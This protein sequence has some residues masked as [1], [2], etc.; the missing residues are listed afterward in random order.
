MFVLVKSA[1]DK[2][3][4]QLPFTFCDDTDNCKLRNTPRM[5]NKLMKMLVI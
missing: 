1:K 3:P 2:T 4:P 5:K